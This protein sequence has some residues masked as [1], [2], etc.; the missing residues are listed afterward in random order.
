MRVLDRSFFSLAVLSA[1]FIM[2]DS[3]V[4]SESFKDK[5]DTLKTQEW[6]HLDPI[7]DG[8]A[9]ISLNKAYQLLE[10]RPSKTVLVAIID[11]G[12][13]LDHEDLKDSYWTNEDEIPN[14]GIDDDKNG[15]V[16]DVH[17]WNFIGGPEENVVYD[18]YELTREYKRLK[19]KF[20]YNGN[21][22]QKEYEYWLKVRDD[23]EYK[24][25]KSEETLI[26]YSEI[27]SNIPRYYKLL[28]SYLDTDTLTLEAVNAIES[29]DTIINQATAQIGK[30][31]NYFGQS[32]G[33]ETMVNVLMPTEEH[34]MYEMNYG[35]NL[36]YDPRS[37]VN[38]DYENKKERYYGNNEVDDFSGM[39][40]DHGTHVAGIIAADRKNDIGARG[41]A[42][43]VKIIPLRTVPNGDERDKDVANAI[44]Y[45]VNNGAKVINMSFGKHYSPERAVVEKAIR[46]A[47]KKGVL[48]VHAAGN[49][50]EN[51]DVILNYPT[52]KF[53][54]GKKE[55]WNVIEVGANNRYLDENLAAKFT[56][57]GETS[58]DLF[59]PGVYVYSTLPNNTYKESSGTSMA[60]PVVSGVAALLFSYFPELSANEIKE[61]IL[62]STQPY[63]GE[64]YLPGTKELVEFP[65]LSVTGGIVNAYEAVKIAQNKIKFQVK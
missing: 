30:L 10:G 2:I 13:D 26:K 31:L 24:R 27:I 63:E 7:D 29:E 51:K 32:V 62:E 16:D 18:T 14:N 58:V 54:K 59:A 28:L 15:Y 55:A 50:K 45:A 20:G 3:P 34:Y 43:N 11:S 44:Y 53:I 39:M 36:E 65:T 9:G 49:D 40:G 33:Y 46:Y 56:N 48:I 5:N 19:T 21:G 57:Y 52:R 23:Y 17:G 1:F 61:V 35:F 37:L 8:L 47:E 6:I 22:S 38:D 25:K 12:F 4:Y 42:D 41:I 64:V 60:A